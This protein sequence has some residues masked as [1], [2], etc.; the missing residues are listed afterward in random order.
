MPELNLIIPYCCIQ[1]KYCAYDVGL[2]DGYLL[3]V[4]TMFMLF[5]IVQCIRGLEEI[6]DGPLEIQQTE[7]GPEEVMYEEDEETVDEVEEEKL[8]EEKP[9]E[10]KKDD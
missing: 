7:V 2:V 3:G 1:G 10:D 5:M 9:E 6:C 4:A 8:D